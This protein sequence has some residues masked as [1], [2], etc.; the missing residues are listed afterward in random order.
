[1]GMRQRGPTI[2][3]TTHLAKKVTPLMRLS[4]GLLMTIGRQYTEIYDF[5]A[6]MIFLDRTITK[7]NLKQLIIMESTLNHRVSMSPDNLNLYTHNRY[8]VA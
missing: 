3:E 2:M 8:K 1:M 4:S 6:S 5:R 7:N